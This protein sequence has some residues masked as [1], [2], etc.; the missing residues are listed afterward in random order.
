MITGKY[1]RDTGDRK[2]Q[3]QTLTYYV[4]GNSRGYVISFLIDQSKFDDLKPTL[5]EMV[6]SFRCD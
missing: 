4:A 6:K 1:E 5:E 2:E 3:M